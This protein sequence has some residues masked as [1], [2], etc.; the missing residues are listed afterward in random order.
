MMQVSF[1]KPTEIPEEQLKIAVIAARFQDKWVFC[2]HKSHEGW[3]IPGGHREPGE[4]I[5]QTASRELREETG[6]V[7]ADIQPVIVYNVQRDGVDSYGML[8]FAQ[9]RE[10]GEL[11]QDSEISRIEFFERVPEELTYPQIHG[12]LYRFLQEWRN[13]QTSSDE[14]WDVLDADRNPT[15]RVHRR[16][17]FLE[18]GDYHLIVHIWVMGENGEFLLTKRTPNKG[19]PNMW[20]ATGGSALTGDDSLT[21]A[22]REVREE[23][24]LALDP[25]RGSCVLQYRRE[26]AFVDVWLFRQ[27]FDL[28]DVILLEG[29]TCDKMRADIP[30]ILDLQAQGRLVP[31]PYLQQLFDL[32]KKREFV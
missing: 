19:F 8:F 5:L 4:S 1:H 13:L 12:P 22:V 7:D 20:E 14:L 6:A 25:M 28:D 24:G 23:T 26:E 17:D 29:E 27:E 30:K 2:K 3:E 16:G 31:F 32:V 10:L 11:T 9:I 18:P 15:G 21:A